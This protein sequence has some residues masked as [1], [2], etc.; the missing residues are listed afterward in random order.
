[1]ARLWCRNSPEGREFEAGNWKTL[2]V[3][4]AVHGYLFRVREGSQGLHGFLV[5]EFFFMRIL[6]QHSFF[7]VRGRGPSN[8]W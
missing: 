8:K 6:A 1:M 7:A 4:P 5:S 2:C 3:D